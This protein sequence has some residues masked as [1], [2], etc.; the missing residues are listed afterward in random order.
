MKHILLAAVVVFLLLFSCKK[1]DFKEPD[2]VEPDP[3]PTDTTR[4]PVDTLRSYGKLNENAYLVDTLARLEYTDGRI[5]L[6]SGAIEKIPKVGDILISAPT[7]SAPLGFMQKITAVQSSGQGY[8]LTTTQAA[9]NEAFSVLKI[10]TVFNT[11]Y[12][13]EA[14]FRMMGDKMTMSM[15]F[16]NVDTVTRDLRLD[17]I[18]QINIENAK[19]KYIKDEHSPLPKEFNFEF[20]INTEG[21]ALDVS[22]YGWQLGVEA[23]PL[24]TFKLPSFRIIVFIPTPLGLFPLPI[25]MEQKIDINVGGV[26]SNGKFRVKVAPVFRAKLGMRYHDGYYEDFDNYTMDALNLDRYCNQDF[27]LQG[28]F[29]GSLQLF[30]PTYS[31]SPYG[32]EVLKFFAEAPFRIDFETKSTSPQYRLGLWFG[33]EGGF[34][35]KFWD[36][37]E[38]EFRL[39][40]PALVNT[41]LAEGDLVYCDQCQDYDVAGWWSGLDPTIQAA[42]NNSI[43][44]SG[45][46]LPVGNDRD[47][48]F[49]KG[50]LEFKDIPLKGT[51]RLPK[52]FARLVGLSISG[53]G[54]QG[55]VLDSLVRLEQLD[56]PRNQLQQLKIADAP[57]LRL[58]YA[59]E[60]SLASIQTDRM[61]RLYILDL[62][63]NL[64]TDFSLRNFPYLESLSID[65]NLLT[66]FP[67]EQTGG[68]KDLAVSGNN[69]GEVD[70]FYAKNLETIECAKT[71]IDKLVC[72]NNPQLKLIYCSGNKISNLNLDGIK[73][74][75][76]LFC[77]R[78]LINSLNKDALHYVAKFDGRDNPWTYEGMVDL[79]QAFP[80][81]VSWEKGSFCKDHGFD[82][83]GNQCKNL[84]EIYNAKF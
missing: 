13:E 64:F 52:C 32:A 55:L 44:K 68:L 49:K 12:Y 2:P 62:R 43:G 50:Y 84:I 14:G 26:S 25:T 16:K 1:N 31:V 18:L 17:G 30:K 35:T 36:N 7:Q 22:Y 70:L 15:E 48:L 71:G 24:K 9:L 77:D 21:S 29:S 4:A 11:S 6:P 38:R 28:Y 67:W 33:I 42:L 20:E 40:L 23:R 59:Q 83:K 39:A 56:C 46:A 47:S 41:T 73:E 74:L 27:I 72:S 10:D 45:T 8:I 51:L 53:T 82:P 63:K 81:Y 80:L 37:R 19:F 34:S 76:Y 5:V 60:N 61:G 3:V 65:D 58:L 57:S 75:K 69:L 79:I 54:L 78:N 66:R